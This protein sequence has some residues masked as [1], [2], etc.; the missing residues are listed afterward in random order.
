MWKWGN[1]LICFQFGAPINFNMKLFIFHLALYL[2]FV[3]C[4]IFQQTHLLNPSLIELALRFY[5]ATASWLNQVALAGDNFDEMT[6]FKEVEIPLP[7]EVCYLFGE[8]LIFVP[9]LKY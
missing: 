3:T 4:F 6:C 1:L 5:I 9:L 7:N 8:Y 2:S